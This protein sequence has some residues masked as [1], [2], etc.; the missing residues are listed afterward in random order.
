MSRVEHRYRKTER[1]SASTWETMLA[2]VV[3]GA[4]GCRYIYDVQWI[5]GRQRLCV[6]FIG[7]EPNGE[8]A[9]Y[10][11]SILHRRM[12]AAR[13]EYAKGLKRYKRYSKIKAIQ[14]YSV[15]WI[16]GHFTEIQKLV[17]ESEV[18]AIVQD[19]F[20]EKYPEVTSKKMSLSDK[21]NKHL[22]QGHIDG[23]QVELNKGMRTADT[24]DLLLN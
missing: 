13:L 1:E 23:K 10:A 7:L 12:K 18:P 19:Y 2:N 14:S 20:M 8:I 9:L 6:N 21:P 5:K 17:P 22:I 3:S 11:F 15:G 4:F 24:S 16:G